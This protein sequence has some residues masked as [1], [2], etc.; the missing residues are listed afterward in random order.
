MRKRYLGLIVVALV[1]IS[2]CW[3][4][5]EAERMDY[6]HG[7]GVDYKD[8]KV[9][10]SLQIVNLGNL[11][12]EKSGGG[13]GSENKSVIA[14]GESDDVNDA[15]FKIY[16]ST[17]RMLYWGHLTFVVVTE[18]ALK[19]GKM[20]DIVDL[21]NRYRETRYR[22][23]MFAT[24]DESVNHILEAAPVFDGSP[25]FTRLTDLG[26]TYEQ[27]SRIKD[28]SLREFLIQI[29]EPGHNGILPAITATEKNWLSEDD[30]PDTMIETLGVALTNRNEFRGFITGEDINGLR[31]L[32]KDAI[33]NNIQVKEDG[34]PIAEGVVFDP[35]FSIKPKMKKDKATFQIDVKGTVLFNELIK[36]NDQH[37][38]RRKVEDFIENEIKHTYRK[39]LEHD[40]DIYRLSEVLYRKDVASWKKIA[41]K[42]K[43][44]LD[45]ESISVTVKIDIGPTKLDNERPVIK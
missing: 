7:V 4:I 33:R 42:G 13:A 20:K 40:S 6:V 45:E 3:D 15:I 19:E 1:F 31:W 43:V 14:E 28:V 41:H 36:N 29:K 25:V 11:G 12:P 10:V 18:E 2:G 37:F 23:L 32:T 27:N 39:A 16:N 35:S 26:N 21:I 44:P 8:G 22:V 38:L 9:I 30:K 5:E 17:Q 34:D 24:Q